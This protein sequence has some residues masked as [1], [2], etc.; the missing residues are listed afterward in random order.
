MT[1][2]GRTEAV[3]IALGLPNPPNKQAVISEMVN[4]LYPAFCFAL[5]KLPSSAAG[6]F[7]DQT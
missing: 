6:S 2:N 3:I 5:K 1:H 7:S 4:C